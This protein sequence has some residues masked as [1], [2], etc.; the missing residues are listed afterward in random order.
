[1]PES[2]FRFK[3]FDIRQDI[4]PM[5]VGTDSVLLGAWAE[6]PATGNILDIGTGTGVLALM[7][8]QKSRGMVTAI[9]PDRP[10]YF[11]ASENFSR[12]PWPE[13]FN[14]I[15]TSLQE[16]AANDTERFSFIIS[17]PPFHSE[18]I[19]P[20]DKGRKNARNSESLP[21]DVLISSIATLLKPD[22]SA[23]II[24]PYSQIKLLEDLINKNGLFISRKLLVRPIPGKDFHRIL[25]Q[26]G[27]M[28][29]NTITEELVIETGKRHHY[30]SEYKALTE[31]FYLFF[32]Y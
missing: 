12:S 8:A 19:T 5:K 1:M 14:L 29:A 28:H 21:P 2:V 30:S 23:A 32:R 6:I 9:E 16:F 26:F 3:E 31:P 22:G 20:P 27:R 15:N 10:S 4:S 17:N 18:T 11:Q 24:Y 7:A 13:R 25:L